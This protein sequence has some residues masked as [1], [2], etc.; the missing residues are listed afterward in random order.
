MKLPQKLLEAI[1]DHKYI[2]FDVYDTLV[3]RTV[4]RPEYVFDM[5]ECKLAESDIHVESFSKRRIDSERKARKLKY[6]TEVTLDDIYDNIDIQEDIKEQLEHLEVDCEVQNA[7]PNAPMLELLNMCKELGKCIIITTD[8]YLPRYFFERLFR[9]IGITY[10]WLFISGEEGVTKYSGELY[11]TVLSRIGIPAD[12]MIHIG[13]NFICDIQNAKKYGVSAYQRII[14]HHHSFKKSDVY[15]PSRW[16]DKVIVDHLLK[17]SSLACNQQKDRSEFIIGYTILGPLLYDFCIWLHRCKL[18]MGIDDLWFLAREGY[19]IKKCYNLLYPD[20]IESRYVRLS[21]NILRLP[22]LDGEDISLNSF[23]DGLI[24]RDFYTWGML[25]SKLQIKEKEKFL[26]ENGLNSTI[27]NLNEKVKR[28]D[29]LEGGALSEILN[30]II[31]ARKDV[32]S[33]QNRLLVKYLVQN[34][35][36]GKKIGLVNN[37]FNGSGQRLL[38]AILSNNKINS[39]IIGLQF[40]KTEV[41]NKTLGDSVQ[42]MLTD[43]NTK[44]YDTCDFSRLTLIFEHLLFEPCGT[45]E[46]LAEEDNLVN[47]ICQ[48]VRHE[49]QNFQ[50]VQRIQQYTLDFIQD[51]HNNYPLPLNHIGLYSLLNLY[52]NPKINEAKI[53]GRLWD[54]DDDRDVKL[55]DED[56]KV[57]FR[58]LFRRHFLSPVYW[59]EGLLAIKETPEFYK[60]YYSLFKLINYFRTRS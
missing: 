52:R 5:V 50:V 36:R 22:S 28:E 49:R 17:L 42:S 41:C 44:Q 45:A 18:Q 29:I 15:L 48:D 12:A 8:M 57:T 3:F 7:V 56:H 59:Y 58:Q 31:K 39:S 43:T 54:D 13:D 26:K 25:L 9:K 32:I 51:Y 46:Y 47:V 21:K 38:N 23:M 19:L 4:S 53:I 14:N 6:P 24:I 11:N 60:K 35:I 37:S 34:D 27:P 2:S 20:E 40:V 30:K 1:T 33:E 10:D 16:G 55:V